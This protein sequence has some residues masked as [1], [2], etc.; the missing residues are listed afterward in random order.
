MKFKI[1]NL[2]IAYIQLLLLLYYCY[3]IPIILFLS[4]I[5]HLS[6]RQEINTDAAKIPS[7][8]LLITFARLLL[9]GK[10]E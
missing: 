8:K 3:S 7:L 4:Q 10:N 9:S 2:K 1:C 5:S 6:S